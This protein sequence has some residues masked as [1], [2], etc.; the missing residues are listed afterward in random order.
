MVALGFAAA[1]SLIQPVHVWYPYR[2]CGDQ[3][4]HQVEGVR[5]VPG[6]YQV[7]EDFIDAWRA[8]P[9][10]D[11]HYHLCKIDKTIMCFFVPTTM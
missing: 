10:E 11:A 7:G 4:C 8:Q 6:G 2:C 1:L 9:S 3:D 5:E